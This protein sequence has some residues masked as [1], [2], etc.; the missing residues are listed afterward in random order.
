M[1]LLIKI[2]NLFIYMKKLLFFSFTFLLFKINF[3]FK[4]NLTQKRAKLSHKGKK[5]LKFYRITVQD[6]NM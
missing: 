1:F 5:S 4:T 6:L 3:I 2:A